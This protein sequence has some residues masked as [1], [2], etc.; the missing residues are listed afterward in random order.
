MTLKSGY[1]ADEAIALLGL[2]AY[3]ET[4]AP[5]PPIPDPRTGWELLFDA[6]VVDS[7][8]NKWQ[9]WRRKGGDAYA[10]VLRGTVDQS[11]SILEDL[12]SLMVKA[13]GA[14]TVGD[15]STAYKFA[16][17]P[18]AGVH[19]GFALGALLLLSDP[20]QGILVRA[21]ANIPAGSDVYIT[22]HSQGAAMATLLASYLHYND[23]LPAECAIKTYVFAQ[24]KPGNQH[25]AEDFEA[26][27]G[28]AAMAFRVT[29]TLDW[30]TEVP[31]T[32]QFP[33]DIDAPNPLTVLASPPRLAALIERALGGVAALI[34]QHTRAHYQPRAAAV[35]AATHPGP[36]PQQATALPFAA[37]FVA[38]LNFVNAGTEAPVAGKPCQGAE[39]DDSLFQH[40][41]T[42][43]YGL[44]IA[45]AA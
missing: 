30:V 11:G 32:P 17:D 8:D 4:G 20:T 31:F 26:L 14:V 29:N 21:A 19:L 45:A 9:L 27:F 22:G 43:Y 44:L 38:S 13:A 1:E 7:F 33:Q 6:P 40:H 16:A 28:D 42:T 35:V 37:D 10:I 36:G 18:E 5:Q 2:C 15:A 25:Y 3:A 24:P 12:I 41:A 34:E 39:S 23:G